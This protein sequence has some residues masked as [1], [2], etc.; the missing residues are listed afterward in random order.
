MPPKNKESVLNRGAACL[1]CRKR[2]LKCDAAKVRV[3]PFPHRSR[4]FRLLYVFSARSTSF[5]MDF[6]RPGRAG[7]Q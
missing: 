5:S 7:R 2:K 1:E 6:A 4:F 3:Y